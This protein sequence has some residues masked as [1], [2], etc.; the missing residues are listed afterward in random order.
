MPQNLLDQ[1][2]TYTVVVADTGD[3]EAIGKF[4]PQDSTTNPSLIA[5]AAQ[6]PQYQP[7]VDGVL[8]GARKELGANATDAAVA[9]LA[10]QRLA[11]EFGKQILAIVP[12]RVSTEVDARLSY[13][14][15]ASI[16]KSAQSIAEYDAA[17][18]GRD[19]ILVKIASTWE[20]I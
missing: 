10:F 18:I 20:G 3:I 19:R 6:M 8:L 17:G 16:S 13:D 2:R 12:G 14:T 5:A 1:L 7:I 15:D 4:R 11:I 9:N